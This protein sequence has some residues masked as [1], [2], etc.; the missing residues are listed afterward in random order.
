MKYKLAIKYPGALPTIMKKV[1][2]CYPRVLKM[3]GQYKEG[4]YEV[5]ILH[6]YKE[7]LLSVETHKGTLEAWHKESI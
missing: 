2:R 7:T 5:S 3:L 6:F 4:A 1:F